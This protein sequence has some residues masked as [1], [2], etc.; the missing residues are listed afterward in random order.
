M[1]KLTKY[2]LNKIGKEVYTMGM[3][4]I[5]LI[6]VIVVIVLW[7]I[8]SQRNLVQLDE[9][10]KNALSQ[11]GVQQNS[12]WDALGALADLTKQYDDHEYSTLMDVIGKRRSITSGS[13]PAD[14]N[15]QENAITEA[16]G[17]IMA[18][19]EAYPNLKADAQ[20]QKTMDSVNQY[21]QNV[22]MS[23]MSCNDTITK[24]NRTLRMIPTC[25]IAGMLG[26]MQREYLETPAEKQDMP[27]MARTGTPPMTSQAA[28]PVAP[29]APA[30][31][32][33]GQDTTPTPPTQG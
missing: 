15:A 6:A 17:K 9:M 32:T 4:I 22:R 14:V 31:P 8:S 1:I 12:R 25:F 5:I 11:I 16:M 29:I 13:S 21:E 27:S 7:V 28:A 3:G 18:I 23:R 19:S 33:P 2:F 24:Y 26:F 10:C 30:E 20:Y